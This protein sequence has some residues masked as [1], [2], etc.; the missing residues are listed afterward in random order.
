MSG[1]NCNFDLLIQSILC[2]YVYVAGTLLLGFDDA[3]CAYSRDLGVRCFVYSTSV[4]L[5]FELG[6]IHLDLNSQ[7]EGLALLEGH[8]VLLCLGGHG[9]GI[10]ER[11]AG[12]SYVDYL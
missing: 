11:S 5:C 9:L 1:L 10:G 12:R 2:V 6:R 7:L 4:C 8:F 3:L